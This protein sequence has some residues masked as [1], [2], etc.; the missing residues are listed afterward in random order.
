MVYLLLGVGGALYLSVAGCVL[1]GLLRSAKSAT[2]AVAVLEM[3]PDG[4]RDEMEA[5]P[6]PSSSRVS[7]KTA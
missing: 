5:Y 2:K 1:L 7:S 3:G 6:S 4:E